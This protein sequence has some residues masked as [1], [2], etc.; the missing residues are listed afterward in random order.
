M[1]IVRDMIF[2][3][4]IKTITGLLIF[5]DGDPETQFL[6]STITRNQKDRYNDRET[7]PVQVLEVFWNW[8]IQ[9]STMPPEIG[10]SRGNFLEALWHL[11]KSCPDY[12]TRDAALFLFSD[13]VRDLMP[14]WPKDR[15]NHKKTWRKRHAEV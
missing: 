2:H 11:H 13:T 1:P 3:R 5:D 12:L 8:G 4:K 7:I 6:L 15:K 9:L 14:R 10:M